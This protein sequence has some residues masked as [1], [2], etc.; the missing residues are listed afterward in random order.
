MESN[1]LTSSGITKAMCEK[2]LHSSDS[3][4]IYVCRNCGKRAVVNERKGIVVCK[5]CRDNA[6]VAKVHTT[7]SSK[8]FMQELESMNVGVRLKLKPFQYEQYM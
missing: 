6:D 8:L 3:F 4:N 2:L 1:V 5:V 7:W